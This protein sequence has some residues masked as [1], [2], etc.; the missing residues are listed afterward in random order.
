M[1]YT[2]TLNPAVDRE[3]TVDEIAFDSVLRAGS[4]RLDYGGKGFNVSRALAAWGGETIAL[5]FVGGPTGQRIAAGLAELGIRTDFVPIAGETRTNISIVSQRESRYIKVNEA[6]PTITPAEE[7]ALLAQVRRLAAAGD[8]WVLSGSLP[9][10]AW[11]GIYAD[12]TRIVQGAGG[13]VILD[14][15]GAPLQHGCRAGPFL[16]KPNAE[17]AGDMVGRPVRSPAEAQAVAGSIHALGVRNLVISLGKEGA[18]FS[19]GEQGWLALP[20]QVVERNPVGAGD[21]LVAGLVWRLSQGSSWPQALQWAVASGAATAGLD[22]TAIGGL[23]LVDSLVDQV[24]L[25]PLG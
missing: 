9:P 24:Q 15:N 2:L 19:D 1:I 13:R 4:V 8:W 25:V 17:E 20:P 22:G 14:T 12:V 7:A 23:E 21:A 6:G 18:L 3:L 10:G 5:G 11:A 16:A